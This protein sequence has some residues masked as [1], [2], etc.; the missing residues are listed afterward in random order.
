MTLTVSASEALIVAGTP[1]LSLNSG[2]TATYTGGSG[3]ASL[4][5]NY[6]VAEGQ[7]ADDLAILAVNLPSGAA[8]RDLAG[9]AVVVTDISIS[10]PAGTLRIDTATPGAPSILSVADD[11]APRTGDLGPGAST[12]DATRWSG[13]RSPA[14]LRATRSRCSRTGRRP[15][16]RR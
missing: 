7:N 15:A 13:S 1:T 5:F 9:N 16:L 3:T 6:T 11:Q 2:G 14:R 4:T 10:N 12:N 8:I